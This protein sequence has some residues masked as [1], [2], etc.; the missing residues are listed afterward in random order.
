MSCTI[1][2]ILIDGPSKLVSEYEIPPSH[3][4][5]EEAIGEQNWARARMENGDTLYF[6]NGYDAVR[7]VTYFLNGTPHFGSGI[8]ARLDN[9]F[10]LIPS[11]TTLEE[12][13][14]MVVFPD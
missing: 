11:I 3:L 13:K 7:G 5:I 8:I 9:Y 2:V 12:A 6:F 4:A 1:R 10:D 14:G